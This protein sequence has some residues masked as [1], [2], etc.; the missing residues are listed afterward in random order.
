VAIAKKIV[1]VKCFVCFEGKRDV[2]NSSLLKKNNVHLRRHMEIFFCSC[3]KPKKKKR[4]RERHK[5]E[6]K[7]EEE[8]NKEKE[9]V[10]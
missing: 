4:E 3:F 7:G 9:K 5:K 1:Q 2:Y 8:N 6:G 10:K